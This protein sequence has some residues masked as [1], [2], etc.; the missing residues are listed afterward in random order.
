MKPWTFKMQT[1]QTEICRINSAFIFGSFGLKFC[2]DS[3]DLFV[4]CSNRLESSTVSVLPPG[5]LLQLVLSHLL[6]HRLQTLEFE[7]TREKC[8][9]VPPCQCLWWQNRNSRGRRQKRIR[10]KEPEHV[11]EGVCLFLKTDRGRARERE[12]CVPVYASEEVCSIG[13]ELR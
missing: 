11:S 12:R 4:A 1:Q 9:L 2:S 5:S 3:S 13:L 10:G 6:Y 7:S 8:G